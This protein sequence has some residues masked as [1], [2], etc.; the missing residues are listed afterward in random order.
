MCHIVQLYMRW[1]EPVW[2]FE[3]IQKVRNYVCKSL[4]SSP[5]DFILS[6]EIAFV[7]IR[8]YWMLM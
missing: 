8:M 2:R 1:C 5:D 6:L 7:G 4:M 3:D